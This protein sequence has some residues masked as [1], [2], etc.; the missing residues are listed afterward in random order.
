MNRKH[1]LKTFFATVLC[2]GAMAVPAFAQINVSIDIGSPPPPARVEVAPKPRS[3]FFW[4]D[5]FWYW[6]GHAHRWNPGHWER[7]RPGYRWVPARWEPRGPRH[8]Y[9]PGRWVEERD[10]RNPGRG[11]A[12]GH[13]KDHDRGPDF[14]RGPDHDRGPH[15]GR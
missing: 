10:M 8:H 12:Y 14:D 11:H 2:L 1:M 6:D 13:D 9:E 3:G 5:G 15:H 4:V 7:M